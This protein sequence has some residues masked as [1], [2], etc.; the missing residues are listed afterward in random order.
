MPEFGIVHSRDSVDI[1]VPMYGSARFD[2]SPPRPRCGSIALRA[3]VHQKEK[4]DNRTFSDLPH[5]GGGRSTHF[6]VP[7]DYN[8]EFDVP[9]RGPRRIVSDDLRF[10]TPH[11]RVVGSR[12][13]GVQLRASVAPEKVAS[14]PPECSIVGIELFLA[15]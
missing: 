13:V 5:A 9:T 15:R 6:G 8:L 12:I 2:S 10:S 7:G 4:A 1:T 14:S 11:V 3:E